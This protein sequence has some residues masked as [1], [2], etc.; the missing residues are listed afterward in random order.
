MSVLKRIYK[1]G[2]IT[3]ISTNEPVNTLE[4]GGG[5]S[6]NAV[7][8]RNVPPNAI[9]R[10]SDTRTPTL[11]GSDSLTFQILGE[12]GLMD[13]CGNMIV[14]SNIYDRD[15]RMYHKSHE[16]KRNQYFTL[17]GVE[18]ENNYHIDVSLSLVL[19]REFVDGTENREVDPLILSPPV[20]DG[21]QRIS[22]VIKYNQ[23]FNTN[24]F[25]QGVIDN[26]YSGTFY[27]ETANIGI[28]NGAIFDSRE[29]IEFIDP[30]F[31]HKIEDGNVVIQSLYRIGTLN[32]LE[33]QYGNL[34]YDIELMTSKYIIVTNWDYQIIVTP[35]N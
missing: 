11:V 17:S 32:G 33:Y 28:L 2:T 6:G 24:N 35:S 16:F 30:E 22:Y 25:S 13:L 8:N 10:A 15:G 9:L 23:L 5:G 14:S 27:N 7:L 3:R 26:K 20:S 21:T 12:K 1:D 29:S 31:T 18:D 19:R 34:Y 4:G